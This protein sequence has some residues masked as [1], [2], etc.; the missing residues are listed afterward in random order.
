[1]LDWSWV[2]KKRVEVKD[3]AQASGLSNQM[4]ESDGPE[5]TKFWKTRF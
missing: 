5:N 4:G 3:N 1:M 2:L